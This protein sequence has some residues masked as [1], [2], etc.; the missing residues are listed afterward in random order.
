MWKTLPRT[1]S[2]LEAR[3]STGILAVS[4]VTL[5]DVGWTHF[6]SSPCIS[7]AIA[8]RSRPS[9]SSPTSSDERRSYYYGQLIRILVGKR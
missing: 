3:S 8:S 6:I 7:L 4:I 9:E 5:S 2:P 1:D